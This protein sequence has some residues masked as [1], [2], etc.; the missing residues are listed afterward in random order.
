MQKKNKHGDHNLNAVQ[1]NQMKKKSQNKTNGKCDRN[2]LIKSNNYLNF[3]SVYFFLQNLI[4]HNFW[5]VVHEERLFFLFSE[6]GLRCL[7]Y[8]DTFD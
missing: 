4:R 3:F 2:Q 1:E 7:R 5:M 6:K 8:D